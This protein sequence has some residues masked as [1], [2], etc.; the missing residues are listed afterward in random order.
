VKHQPDVIA[1]PAMCRF[2]HVYIYILLAC[3]TTKL[4]AF[5]LNNI[6]KWLNGQTLNLKGFLIL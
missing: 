1:V 5:Y 6:L 4:K 3:A 2:V